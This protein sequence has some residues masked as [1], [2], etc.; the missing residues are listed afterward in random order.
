[1]QGKRSAITA[2]IIGNAL[3]WFDFTVY[4]LFALHIAKTFFPVGSELASLLLALATFGVGFVLRPVGAVILG[5]Y[6]DR[7][8][9]RAAMTLV[10]VLMSVG[11]AILA[12]T[13]GFAAIGLAAP[14][15]IVI[16]RLIQGFSAG[17]EMGGATAYLIESAPPERRGFYAS[18]QFAGQAA[19]ALAGSLIAFAVT[20][21]LTPIQLE[22]W[23]WRTP[24][25]LGLSIGPVGFYLRRKMADSEE[26]LATRAMHGFPLL[27]LLR[28][29]RR[30]LARSFGV[31]VLGT[32][33]TYLV[34][35]N[36]PTYAVRQLD[37]DPG[38]SFIA[39]TLA[40]VILLVFNPIAGRLSD[41]IGRQRQILLSAAAIGIS[42]Y[43]L[44]LLLISHPALPMLILVQGVLAILL[45]LYIGPSAALIGEMFPAQIRSTGLSLGYNIAV[46]LFGGFAPFWVT[47]LDTGDHLAA[48][49]YIICCAVL[50]IAILIWT[51]RP[52]SAASGNA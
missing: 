18:W 15:L 27:E 26:F 23:G 24:F 50:T 2:A 38:D 31:T 21:A 1:M 40:S 32:A 47:R 44:L 8:G 17:G 36:M 9:R 39:A 37:M 4:S 6:A 12:F 10:I 51:R 41:R 43:P 16:A 30:Q 11:T 5:Q 22:D 7:A 48:A 19:A 52:Y 33:C 29:Y 25:I 3:E 14:V 49:Y 13:P 45:A 28:R 35:L 20:R 34:I 42:A 46:P